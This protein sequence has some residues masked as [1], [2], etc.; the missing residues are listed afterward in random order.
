MTDC[1]AGKLW[2]GRRVSKTDESGGSSETGS[3]TMKRLQGWA[4]AIVILGTSTS[5]FAAGGDGKFQVGLRT[6]YS[7]FAGKLYEPAVL[8]FGGMSLSGDPTGQNRA[9]SGQVPIWLDAGYQLT[10]NLM[11][12]LYGQYGFV[13]LK[14]DCPGCSAHDLRFGIQGQYRFLPTGS[15]DPWVGLGVGY[16]S[17]S[18]SQKV[19]SVT[20]SQGNGTPLPTAIDGTFSGWEIA[21]LQG[22]VDFRLVPAFTLGPFVSV[23]FDEFTHS[24]IDFHSSTFPSSSGSIGSKALHEWITLG[25]KGTFDL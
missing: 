15:A 13:T 25:A 14:S 9:V 18:L 8:V 5:A 3:Q 7:I 20:D 1:V 4:V 24:S 10:P 2:R 12:G 19:P 21:N 11:L 6:G 17:L 22:G 23:S 16:E